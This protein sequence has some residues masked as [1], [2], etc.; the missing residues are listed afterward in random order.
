MA[1]AEAERADAGNH[2]E[3]GELLRIVGNPSRHA[4][5]AEKVLRKKGDIEEDH[6]QPEV[7][8][9]QRLVIHV[10]GPFR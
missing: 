7:K 8:F 1:E 4:G 9:P 6:R 3:V 10:T 2:V 5:Q